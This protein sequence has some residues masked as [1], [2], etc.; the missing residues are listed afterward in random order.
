MS[1][2]VSV[3]VS[4]RVLSGT[5]SDEQ[6]LTLFFPKR[7]I[8][9]REI[10][11]ERVRKEVQAYNEQGSEIFRGLVTPEDAER[12]L[13][14]FRIPEKRSIDAKA[15]CKLACQAFEQNGFILLVDDRQVE[16]LDTLIE[17]R[18]N[19]SVVFLKLTPLVGG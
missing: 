8:T 13:N 3:T 10:I 5:I 19:S 15:Q 9:A 12:T 11:C 2:Q 16:A 4:D 6:I 18:M 7:A 1:D 17:V 14:G